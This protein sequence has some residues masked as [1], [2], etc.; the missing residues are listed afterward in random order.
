MPS[1]VTKPKVTWRA[2]SDRVEHASLPRATRTVCGGEIVTENLAWP[3]FRKCMV[4]QAALTD[5]PG[6]GL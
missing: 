1:T 6:M 3:P 5:N 2:A 4:C